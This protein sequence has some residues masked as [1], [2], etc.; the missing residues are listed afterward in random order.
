MVQSPLETR[1]RLQIYVAHLSTEIV[2]TPADYTQRNE[3]CRLKA[4]LDSR[5]IPTIGYGCCGLGIAIGLT[6]THNQANQE[7][8]AR[9]TKATA[10]AALALGA[11]EWGCLDIVRR[12]VLSDLSYNLGY[13][14]LEEFVKLLTDIR[15]DIHP[16]I[17]AG[18]W[19]DASQALMDSAYARQLPMRANR[20]KNML[21]S[22]QWPAEPW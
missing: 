14:G 7:F 10:D 20:N 4:Y 6:W 22:G 8:Y 11:V 5:G 17:I 1:N 13:R 15:A 18:N 21:I 19:Y 2:M 16:H 3:G 9:F 12:A